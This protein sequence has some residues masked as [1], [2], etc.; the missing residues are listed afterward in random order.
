MWIIR[1]QFQNCIIH[2]KAAFEEISQVQAFYSSMMVFSKGNKYFKLWSHRNLLALLCSLWNSPFFTV[3]CWTR[4]AITV[5][6][7]QI[8][9][10]SIFFKQKKASK[11]IWT[12]PILSQ[13][14]EGIIK[15]IISCCNTRIFQ[16][17]SGN[18]FGFALV[19]SLNSGLSGKGSL[20]SLFKWI[21]L[22]QWFV[23]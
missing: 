14:L 18:R 20:N 9:N 17:V 19:S 1:R 16:I 5:K 15:S 10:S 6:H 13:S 11:S 23:S 22:F 3:D 4:Q 7:N 21:N 12:M 2:R 8:S